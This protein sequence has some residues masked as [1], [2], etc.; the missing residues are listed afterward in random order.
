MPAQP[1]FTPLIFCSAVTSVAAM[2]AS[3]RYDVP[4]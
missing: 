1:L 2:A 4:P 3:V